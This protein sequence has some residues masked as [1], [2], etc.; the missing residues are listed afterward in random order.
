MF[1]TLARYTSG[2][3]KTT[4][5]GYAPRYLSFRHHNKQSRVCHIALKPFQTIYYY[6]LSLLY[7]FIVVQ[8]LC[9]YSKYTTTLS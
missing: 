9:L 2:P 7:T 1:L 8:N 3:P 6:C 5:I 4:I